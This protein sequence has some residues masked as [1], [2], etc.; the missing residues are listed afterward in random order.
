MQ[1]IYDNDHHIILKP[2]ADGLRPIPLMTVSEWSN[3][4]RF[5][6]S[7]SS[8]EP[9][10]YRVSRMPY[11]REIMDHLGQTSD[12][13]EVV[14]VKSSQVGGTELGNCWVGYTIHLDPGPMMI[15]M[16]TDDAIKK[17]SRT[18]IRPMIESSPVLNE[19]IK[20]V[21]SKD[22]ENTINNKSF[23]GGALI[24]VGANSPTPLSSTPI[25]KLMLDEVDRYP[26]S[27]GEEGSPV[28]LAR[29]RTRTFA[30]RKIL[31]VSTPT[32]EGT[33][34]IW[35]EFLTTDQRYYHVPCQHCFKLFVLKFEHL[36]WIEGQ[37]E[38]VELA[39]PECGGCHTEKDKTPMFE[40]KGFSENGTAEWIATAVSDN[41]RK[42][43]Y[44]INSLYSPA[45]FYSWEEVVRDYLK[46]KGDANKEQTFIN[47]VLGETYKIK[48]DVPEYQNLYNRR[49]TYK[50]G[51][52]PAGVYFLTMGV[53]VQ[54]DRLECE[55]V[56]WGVGRESW[57]VDYRVLVG[58]TTKDEVW[59]E[60]TEV[61]NAHFETADGSLMHLS[62]TAIDSG[63]NTKKVY[64]YCAK[65]SR[66]KV[67]P[68]KGSSTAMD[69][70][71]R[72]PKAVN[73]TS[74]GK[75]IKTGRVWYLGTDLLKT[76]LY[77]FLGLQATGEDAARIYP[78]GY[79]HFPEYN[80][81]Y[82]KML[83]AEEQRT[84]VNKKGYSKYEWV[85]TRPRNEALDIRCYARAAAH[86]LGIDRLKGAAWDKIKQR[87]T[88]APVTVENSEKKPIQKVQKK[89]SDYWNKKR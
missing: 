17:N 16:P 1:E 4:F 53:D 61:I 24:M 79:C 66:S 80:E 52:V 58:D 38:T 14:Y 77:G 87:V 72:P 67:I 49:E 48:G 82:F 65:F 84:A 73:V 41:P 5:L 85:K 23:P 54:R 74:S 45:G 28:E 8:A 42:T 11:N 34:V 15:V 76:E 36:S 88:T 40:E 55:I 32:V 19:K 7:A 21:G 43:G 6:T 29:A 78:P 63:D 31:M 75:S 83:T 18:R 60:L 64:D 86:I 39:C 50:R 69:T 56:G 35:A 2:F 70:M 25:K 46:A 33:S 51:T 71:V 10:R 26:L 37:P 22:A 62:L 89:K 81:E 3:E 13:Q 68:V 47:T 30:N 44:H 9:G 12:M 27:A 57:S 20:A 59:A